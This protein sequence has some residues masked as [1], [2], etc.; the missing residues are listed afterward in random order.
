M[1]PQVV[2]EEDLHQQFYCDGDHP[3]MD[4]HAYA[5]EHFKSTIALRIT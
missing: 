2:E 5:K 1:R 4:S 3:E